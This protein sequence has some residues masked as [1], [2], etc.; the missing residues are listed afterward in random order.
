MGNSKI[1]KRIFIVIEVESVGSGQWR[2]N[3]RRATVL[4][5]GIR[6]GIT[7]DKYN[8][9]GF[10]HNIFLILHRLRKKNISPHKCSLSPHKCFK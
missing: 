2:Q 4:L 10:S 5:C 6:I 7:A 3:N 9:I 1:H 8:C